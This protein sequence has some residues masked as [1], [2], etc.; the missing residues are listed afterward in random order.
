VTALSAA[1]K[2]GTSTEQ[3]SP[4]AIVRRL[5][6][7]LWNRGDLGVADDVLASDYV[8]HPAD[9]EPGA[10]EQMQKHKKGP[11]PEGIKQFVTMFRRA[12]P[13]LIFTIDEMIVDGN[14]VAMRLT[15]R[16]TH[17]GEFGG[18]EATGKPVT[19]TGAA[20]HH[21]VG[22]KIAETYAYVDRMGLRAQL[23]S[24]P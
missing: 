20:F 22:D 5:I 21:I 18:I 12:F 8:E 14:R 16:G 19:V 24:T 2:T 13:D 17:Q 4:E 3:T 7:E 1:E 23:T 6:D 11:G 9:P 10:E 15:G